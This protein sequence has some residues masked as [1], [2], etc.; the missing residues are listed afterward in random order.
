MTYVIDVPAVFASDHVD[1]E[2]PSGELLE[3]G[4]RYWKFA[5]SQDEIKEWLS[6]AHFYADENY[7][8]S[9]TDNNPKGEFG[10]LLP[11]IKSAKRAIK[12]V[13]LV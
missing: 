3:T 13:P 4:K 8:R 10:N 9:A 5:C 1:R 2:L 12:I 6:D 7:W 11:I